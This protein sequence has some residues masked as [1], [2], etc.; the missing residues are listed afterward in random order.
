MGKHD[1]NDEDERAKRD[2]FVGWMPRK[3]EPGKHAAEDDD[4][5]NKDQDKDEKDKDDDG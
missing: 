5:K 3:P 2:G 1:Q 4:P